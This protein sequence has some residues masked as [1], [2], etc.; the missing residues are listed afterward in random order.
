MN[1]FCNI[2]DKKRYSNDHLKCCRKWL[3]DIEGLVLST[4]WIESFIGKVA[5]MPLGVPL[6]IRDRMDRKET[7]FVVVSLMYLYIKI[8]M[9]K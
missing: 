8:Y 6:A 3:G 7:S 9:R 1:L 2:C 5:V 4:D